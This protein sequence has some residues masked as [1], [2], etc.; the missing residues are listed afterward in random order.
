MFSTLNVSM[1]L[2]AIL[3][4]GGSYAYVASYAASAAENKISKE[5]CFERVNSFIID[6]QGDETVDQLSIPDLRAALQDYVVEGNY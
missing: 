2:V 6:K 3:S 4:I 5:Q 1:L